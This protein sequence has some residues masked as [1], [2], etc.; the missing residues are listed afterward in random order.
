MHHDGVDPLPSLAEASDG[1]GDNAYDI[2][3]FGYQVVARTGAGKE[4][5]VVHFTTLM[6]AE[7]FV[8]ARRRKRTPQHARQETA[9]VKPSS[10]ADPAHALASDLRKPLQSVQ[11]QMLGGTMPYHAK[12]LR[13][14]RGPK[15]FG[16]LVYARGVKRPVA[17]SEF[18]YPSEADAWSAAGRIVTKL[19]RQ[20]RGSV[21]RSQV[22]G[23]AASDGIA[24]RFDDT[25]PAMALTE[26]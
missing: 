2:R 4:R 10:G 11:A 17:K 6:D 15:P 23:A 5:V 25:A 9:G 13:V 8:S 19:E 12:V 22:R 24:D 7:A 3:A 21:H 18:G 14:H 1:G 16:W 20:G 26:R